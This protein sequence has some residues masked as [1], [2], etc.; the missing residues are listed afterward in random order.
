MPLIEYQFLSPD[1]I[2]HTRALG[3][4]WRGAAD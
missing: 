2:I 3:S 4:V 1:L